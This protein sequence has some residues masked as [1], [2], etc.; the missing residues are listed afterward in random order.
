MKPSQKYI[1]RQFGSLR[2]I[3]Y[4]PCDLPDRH[5]FVVCQC[6]CGN[7]ARVR[8]DNLNDRSACGNCIQQRVREEARIGSTTHNMSRTPTYQNWHGMIQ[9][10]TNPNDPAWKYYGGRGIRVHD[11]WLQ[12]ENFFADMGE[13]PVGTSLDR[14]PDNNGNYEPGNVRWATRKEQMRN[15]RRNHMVT[16]ASK[17]QCVTDWAIEIGI[18]RTVVFSRI[19][20]GWSA[21]D[22]LLTPYLG[23]GQARPKGIKLTP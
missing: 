10:C 7:R 6:K 19:A 4:I 8:T 3:S 21:E 14:W 23:K 15:T 9:R 5:S 1:N 2:I 13:R 11:S 12:F 17:T 18:S 22:A 20:R 16:I